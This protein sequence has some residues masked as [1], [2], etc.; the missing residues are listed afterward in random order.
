MR[1]WLKVGAGKA[2]EQGGENEGILDKLLAAGMIHE[3]VPASETRGEA[4]GEGAARE[5]RA[6]RE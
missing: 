4:D 2:G 6:S 1:I 3:Y 5:S